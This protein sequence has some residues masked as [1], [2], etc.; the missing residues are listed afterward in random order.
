MPKAPRRAAKITSE[1][2]SWLW[3]FSFVAGG[4]L[5][6]GYNLWSISVNRTDYEFWNQINTSIAGIIDAL[7]YAIPII[8]RSH[9]IVMATG[10]LK[11][12]D[13]VQNI[14]AMD[15]VI[16]LIA[17]FVALPFISLRAKS[18]T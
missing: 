2:A 9:E 7:S 4:A 15:W 14:Y 11:R 8:G 10:D 18:A 16:C 6:A 13:L 5:S 3:L 1:T 17:G 12:A